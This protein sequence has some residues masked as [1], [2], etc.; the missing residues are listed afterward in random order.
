MQDSEIPSSSP[1]TQVNGEE[2]VAD[3]SKEFFQFHDFT[4]RLLTSINPLKENQTKIATQASQ[5]QAAF[6]HL[7]VQLCVD[8]LTEIKADEKIAKKALLLASI[9]QMEIY[10]KKM[11]LQ[12]MELF[13]SI[14]FA[15]ESAKK[16][17]ELK[18]L[19][20]KIEEEEGPD[21][22]DKVVV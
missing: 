11:Y 13:N 1:S 19:E 6:H 18:D 4:R 20:K 16:E 9:S 8:K 3:H 10:A 12:W 17:E 14:N 22:R 21:F 5:A 15:I 7:I 2:K